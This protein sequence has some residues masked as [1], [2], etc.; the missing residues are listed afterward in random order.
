MTSVSQVPTPGPPRRVREGKTRFCRPF[1]PVPEEVDGSI[2]E[3]VLAEE[4]D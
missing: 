3:W 4:N 2:Q 1:E